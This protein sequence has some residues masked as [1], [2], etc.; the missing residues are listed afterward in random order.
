[1]CRSMTYPSTSPSIRTIDLTETSFSICMS[2]KFLV[3]VNVL[4]DVFIVGRR[5]EIRRVGVEGLCW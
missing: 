3:H 4:N 1:M 2:I 5:R